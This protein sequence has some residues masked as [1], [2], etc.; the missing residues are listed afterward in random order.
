MGGVNWTES[1]LAEWAKRHACAHEPAIKQKAPS[2]PKTPPKTEQ[3]FSN[4]LEARRLAGEIQSWEWSSEPIVL[5]RYRDEKGT[6]RRIEYRPDFRVKLD[7]N[8]LELY[9]VKGTK[10]PK[11]GSRGKPRPFIREDAVI[12]LHWVASVY[13]FPIYVT[14]EVGGN[15]ERRR[16]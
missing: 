1:E 4:Y 11:V 2:G 16:I 14:W 7:K 8:N 13:A 10:M 3:R 15:W 9:D 12:K 5:R 6:E